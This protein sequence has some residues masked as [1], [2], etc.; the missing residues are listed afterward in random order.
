[1][2]AAAEAVERGGRSG[3]LRIAAVTE[4]PNLQENNYEKLS[5]KQLL[6]RNRNPINLVVREITRDFRPTIL[7]AKIVVI[8]PNKSHVTSI[9]QV[10]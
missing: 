4:P 6:Y 1:M 10:V 3:A 8:Q 2:A 5:P 9:S 7:Q